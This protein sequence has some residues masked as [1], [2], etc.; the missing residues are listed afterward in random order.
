MLVAMVIE[1]WR[2]GDVARVIEVVALLLLGDSWWL[3]WWLLG[4][5]YGRGC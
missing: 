1:R 3:L 4:W 2:D 5:H